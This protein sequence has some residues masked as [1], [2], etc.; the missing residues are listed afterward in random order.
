[1]SCFQSKQMQQNKDSEIMSY[2]FG[3]RELRID[4]VPFVLQ[5]FLKT[6]SGA[7]TIYTCKGKSLQVDLKEEGGW[8]L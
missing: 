5:K 6:F 4:A 7:T 8:L 2:S 1:M 3:N